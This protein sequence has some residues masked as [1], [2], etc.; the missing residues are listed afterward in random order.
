MTTMP[1]VPYHR[2]DDPAKLQRLIEAVLSIENAINLPAGLHHLVREACELVGARYGALGVLDA[3]GT[4]LEEF[5]TVGLSEDEEAAI[6]ERPTGQGVLGVLIVEPEPLRLDNVADHADSFGFPPDHPPMATFLGVPIQ[7]RGEPYGNLYLT[8]KRGGEPFTAEDEAMVSA[9]AVAAGI[10]VETARLNSRV[11]E[12]TLVE[13]RDRIARDLH[14]VVIQ[15]LFALGLSLQGSARVAQHDEL[16]RRVHQAVDDI[17]D[18]IRQIRTS[19]F[20]LEGPIH[21]HQLRRGVLDLAD[22]MSPVIGSEV[23][24]RFEGPVDSTVPTHLGGQ[25]LVTAREALSNAARHS[26]ATAVSVLVRVDDGELTLQV[27]DNGVGLPPEVPGGGHGLRNMRSRAEKLGGTCE[28][29]PAH[30][31]TEVDWRVPL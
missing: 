25:L 15:R 28:V 3:S 23:R 10:A 27:V 6:G 22:E 21:A 5:I 26:R 16:V 2:I 1:A 29:S 24:V 17:D 31:G 14:D 11:R 19:I 13:D 30:P 8:E 4:G 9:L 12:L 20:D 7:I 18:T